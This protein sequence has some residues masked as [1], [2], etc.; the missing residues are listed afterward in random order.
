[1]GCYRLTINIPWTPVRPPT[2]TLYALPTK[3]DEHA[4]AVSKV[5]SGSADGGS[6][7]SDEVTY[8]N[9][10]RKEVRYTMSVTSSK[11]R[12]TTGTI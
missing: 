4:T 9:V 11:P 3:R 10:G 2:D 8:T 7:T 5:S 12:T 6:D 1:M